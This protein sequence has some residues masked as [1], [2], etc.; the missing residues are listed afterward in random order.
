MN[1]QAMT[2]KLGTYSI[3]YIEDEYNI[4][5][6][7]T[8][9]LKHYFKAV[10]DTPTSEEGFKL[11]KQHQPDIILLDIN[12][13]GENG[14]EFAKKI[15]EHDTSTRI[16]ISTAYATKEFMLEAIELNLMR[17]LIKPLTNED[18][19]KAFEKCLDTIE[20]DERFDLG[21]GYIY[22]KRKAAVIKNQQLIPLRRKEVELL[23]FF[24]THKAEV[25]PYEML[26]NSIWYDGVMTR[27]AIRSQIRNIRKKIGTHCLQN[28]TGIGYKFEVK[29]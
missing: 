15:R 23:E 28:I 7:I 20:K 22:D 25:L 26:E 24:I 17:Y 10:Y 3:L 14:I 21:A 9:F 29:P 5:R 19:F 4:R 11:Y 16:L 6:H 1:N 13:P 27:D 12:L 8:E 2:Q 18:L